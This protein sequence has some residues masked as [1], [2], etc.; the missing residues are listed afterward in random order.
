VDADVQ[1]NYVRVQAGQ[2]IKEGR[3]KNNNT[4]Q[5]VLP[6]EVLVDSPQ[7]KKVAQRIAASAPAPGGMLPAPTAPGNNLKAMGPGE[8][9]RSII[10]SAKQGKSTSEPAPALKPVLGPDFDDEEEVPPLL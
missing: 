7:K 1:P 6:S 8:H 9:V 5:L 4:L 2:A 3:D 10:S